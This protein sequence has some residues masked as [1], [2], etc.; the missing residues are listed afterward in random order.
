V[1]DFLV[2]NS[3]F[4]DV[5]SY[6]FGLDIDRDILLAGVELQR[7]PK[8]LRDDYHIAA[9][10]LH[11]SRLSAV[12]LPRAS[13]MLHQCPLLIRQTLNEGSAL[14]GGEELYEFVHR[15]GAQLIHRVAAICE[16][17]RHNPLP[18]F[19]ALSSNST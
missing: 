16:L 9:V 17:S 3:E 15:H 13:Y 8:H 5:V 18:G 12:L 7:Q 19:L 11:S 6:H 4:S 14:S 1:D 10:R 2:R